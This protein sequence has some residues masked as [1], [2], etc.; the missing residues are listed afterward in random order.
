MGKSVIKASAV[1]LAFL[2]LPSLAVAAGLGKLTV[3]SGLGQPLKAEIELLA[4]QKDEADNLSVHLPPPDAFRQANIEYAGALLTI[5]F[6]IE[7]RGEGQYVVTLS[8]TQPINEPFLDMLVELD[9][10]TSRLV[11]E[12]TFLL[13]PPGY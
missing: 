4:V 2:L 9:S 11:R 10:K 13:D 3:F 5:K 12:Y 1:A 8:S 6:N 7:Q